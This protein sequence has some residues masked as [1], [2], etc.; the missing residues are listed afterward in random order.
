MKKLFK[1]IISIIIIIS[2]VMPNINLMDA[3]AT[4]SSNALDDV[5]SVV[6]GEWEK[7]QEMLDDVASSYSELDWKTAL[8]VDK[9]YPN[10]FHNQVQKDLR[11]RYNKL[12]E[13]E[14]VVHY[15]NDEGEEKEGRI[16]LVMNTGIATYIWEVK[17]KSYEVEPNRSKGIKQLDN[18]KRADASRFVIGSNQIT[19]GKTYLY[20]DLYYDTYVEHV[21]YT[22]DYTVHSD[23]LIIYTFRRSSTKEEKCEEKVKE[24]VKAQVPS[25]AYALNDIFSQEEES[26]GIGEKMILA[27]V[28]TAAALGARHTLI[29]KN[30][31]N[32]IST[33]IINAT[34]AFL[35]I[36]GTSPETVEAAELEAAYNEFLLALEVYCGDEISQEL[37][38]ALKSNDTEK[39][40]ELL[41]EIQEESDEYD[42]AGRKQPPND[43]LVV[44]MGEEGI[45]LCSIDEGVNFDLD[46]N[47]FSEK[48]AWIGNEDGFLALDRNG[49]GI[50]DNGS[51]LFGDQVILSDG[52]KST[53]GFVALEDVDNNQD[54]IIDNNDEIFENL[55]I[56]IDENHNGVSESNELK[57]LMELNIVSISLEYEE[58]SFVDSETGTRIEN[59]SSVKIDNT[60]EI[61]TTKIS[62]FW[63]PINSTDTTQGDVITVGNISDISL[64]LAD[65]SSGELYE[66]IYLF[67]ETEEIVLKRY[68]IKQILYFIADATE[69]DANSRGGNIDA[70][71]LKVIE[72]FMGREF[73]GIGGVNPNE[74]AADILK[75]IYIS[76][77]DKYY[78]I[79]NMYCGFGAYLK[80]VYEYEDSDGNTVLNLDFINYMIESK[81]EKCENVDV[82]LYDLGVYLRTYDEINSTN[83]YNGYCDYYSSFST[84]YAHIVKMTQ[85]EKTE[86]GTNDS[87]KIIG[88]SGNDFIYGMAGNDIIYGGSGNDV[89]VG[90][91][92]NDTLYGE[93]GSDIYY[94]EASWG[95]D[96]IA[97][98]DTGTGRAEDKI[99]FGEGI[100]PE[101]IQLSKSG[102]HMY[103]KNIVTGDVIKLYDAYYYSGK[104][105]MVENI[106]FAD[107]TLWG[108]E[109]ITEQIRQTGLNGTDGD[110]SISGVTAEYGYTSNEILRGGAGN[111]TLYGKAGNDI[112]IGGAGN[113][114]LQGD[115]GSDTYYFE[116]GWGNDII[117]NYDTSTGRV[118]DKILFGEGI[119]IEDLEFSRSDV[120]MYIK[121][122]STGDVIKVFDAYYY[123]NNKY[124]MIDN[125]EFAD[126][127]IFGVEEIKAKLQSDGLKGTEGDDS[128]SGYTEVYGYSQNETFRGY[129]GNDTLTGNAGDDK[130]YGGEGNDTIKGG[131]GNDVLVGE[132]GNDTLQGDE[133]SDIYYFEIGWGSD[134]IVNYDTGTGR[135]EDKILFGAGINPEDIQ[136]SKSGNHMYIKNV[137]TGDVI[138]VYDA[139]YYG[140][141]KYGMIENIEFADGTLWGIEE[142]I[143]QIRQT[144]LNGTDGND[145]ISG[146]TATYGYTSNEILRGGAGNDTLYG[147][148]GDDILIGGSGND[149][150]QG[151]EGSDTYYF[152]AGWGNDTIGNYDTSTGRIGDKI[153]FGEGVS[154]E[155]LSIS[156]SGYHMYITNNKTNDAIK[157]FDQYYYKD[158]SA[159]LDNVEFMDGTKAIIDCD[160]LVLVILVDENDAIE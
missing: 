63:F 62:E 148:A 158:N 31:P 60:G 79:I 49:N 24:P 35:T 74:S 45:E 6:Q 59:S 149:T 96:T 154:I 144:G 36:A 129:A 111:D 16:D 46:N 76:I 5:S 41:K 92:G 71:E 104:Y 156:R 145:S 72:E 33:A 110:D 9:F 14:L 20:K 160:N 8:R 116:P 118:G 91:V 21:T 133:G 18:Y 15:V 121:N 66:L 77:E 54:K 141:N 56:W 152:E 78:N 61:I 112:L 108:I 142:I 42:E 84:H 52:N 157:I 44:D 122:I 67:S 150:L 4:E 83:Y 128:I 13:K 65:D 29:N 105:G 114:V 28:A 11:D 85:P 87:E 103:I 151:D 101:D 40:E 146:V 37:L 140:N 80:L 138:K 102:D 64:A 117:G 73:V 123:G 155:D 124:G 109:E 125:I 99:L 127:T 115:E 75:D 17:P 51:E 107:G 97:N 100:N 98:Y 26:E 90:G 89:L 19:G 147:K 23:G 120:H 119:S 58:V 139:Y 86:E 7:T 130:L 126:G 132:S 113:D 48:T 50:I 82:L 81:I 53:S 94:F 39:I 10:S 34:T 47:G 95:S 38:I 153:L 32:S 135:V 137:S 27:A 30:A 93:N 136:L 25:Y 131:N 134:T 3:Y 69:V 55:L 68:Y 159:R 57:T 1:R 88:L 12:E 106:E 2:M 70:R 43:P 22:I 143:E